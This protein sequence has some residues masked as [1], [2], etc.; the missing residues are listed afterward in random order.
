MSDMGLLSYYL[1]IEV[2]QNKNGI[3]LCQ[4]AYALKL[5]KKDGDEGL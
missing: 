4:S 1:G 3:S 2:C 5:L